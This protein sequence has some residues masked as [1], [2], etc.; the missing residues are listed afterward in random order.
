MVP[1][2]LLIFII[3]TNF[4]LNSIS[5]LLVL[6]C[7]YVFKNRLIQANSISFLLVLVCDY[8]FK[9][10]LIH[11]GRVKNYK[12]TVLGYLNIRLETLVLFLA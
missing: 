8:I 3:E 11:I 5:F 1:R 10:R 7:D 9:N 4:I 12:K 2:F 6:V